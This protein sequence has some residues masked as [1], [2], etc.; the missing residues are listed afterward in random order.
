MDRDDI[1]IAQLDR[2]EAKQDKLAEQ[3]SEVREATSANSASIA[4][5]KAT[6]GTMFTAAV[7]CLVAFFKMKS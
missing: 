4:F 5:L 7:T 3:L 6:V 2:I 1:I